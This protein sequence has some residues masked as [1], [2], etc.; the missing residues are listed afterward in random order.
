MTEIQHL[1]CDVCGVDIIIG[2]RITD[3]IERSWAKCRIGLRA[4]DYCPSCWVF[5][6]EAAAERARQ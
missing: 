2:D 6:M 3:P 4:Y 1:R 5:I